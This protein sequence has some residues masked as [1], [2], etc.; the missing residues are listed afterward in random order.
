MRR[1]WGVFAAT[2]CGVS[3]AQSAAALDFSAHGYFRTRY[4]GLWNLDTQSSS[5]L[6][7]DRFGLIQFNQMRLRVEPVLKVNDHL[8]LHTQFDILDNVLFGTS[9][10]DELKIND[11]IVGTIALPPGAGSLSLTGGQ[12]G[13]NASINVR[14]AWMDIMT[15][16]GK[17]RAGRQPAHWGLGIFQNDG[18]GRQGDFGDTVDGITY[19]VQKDFSNGGAL[20]MGAL[21]DTAYEAQRDPRIGGLA[22]A[23][24][25]N[26]QDT[27]QWGALF[28]YERPEFDAGLLGVFRKRNGSSGTTTTATDVNGTTRAAGIDG[29]TRMYVI[30]G[31]AKYRFMPQHS[32]AV[33]MV[34]IGGT[35]ST[36]VAI[37]AIPFRGLAAPGIIQ[38]PANQDVAVNLAAVEAEGHYDF[39]GEWKLQGGFA[40]GDGSPL[41]QRITQFGFRPDY[42]IGLLMFHYPLG[43]SPTLRD[44]TSGAKLA[45][46][47]PISGNY[48]NNAIY[49]SLTYMQTLDV[50]GFMPQANEFKAGVR[51]VTAFAHRDPVSLNFAE[52]LGN[53]N[54]PSVTSRGKWYGAEIDA[55]VDATFFDHL[56][57]SL[58]LGG[59]VPGSAFDINTN[60][61]DP[62][63]IV[64]TIPSDK[65]DWAMG[66]RLTVSMEF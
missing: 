57:T 26:G 12:A 61:V 37:N 51:V 60:L 47:V 38:L 65:A 25:D 63:S 58:E 23:I 24:R 27:N 31:Y 53:A 44:G 43:S 22:T 33:E 54:M 17:I 32:V 52:I 21:W 4:S 8:S 50:S 28:F 41:S 59:L 19:L 9:N 16:I 14:R 2:L 11:A 1:I 15:P 34:R 30:D 62:G 64:A 3:V 10:T 36:G 5:A 13:T 56:H 42:Q 55:I 35:V 7:N 40:E 29:N 39:G 20:T 18:N 49:G 45:G 48:I 46:G 66:G 6:A